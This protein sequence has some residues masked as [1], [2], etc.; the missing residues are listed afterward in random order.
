MI[1]EDGLKILQGFSYE[2]CQNQS[3]Q[4]EYINAHF[5]RIWKTFQVIESFGLS[6]DAKILDVGAKPY[7]LA[8][9]I[10]SSLNS[11]FTG[12]GYSLD[13]IPVEDKD[14]LSKTGS[15]NYKKKNLTLVNKGKNFSIEMHQANVEVDK[16]PFED[17][18][19]DVVVFTE[20]LEHLL[21]DVSFTIKEINR[22]LK[23]NGRLVFSTPNNLFWGRL[24]ALFLGK[25]IDDP[26]SIH[27][28]YGRHNR[29]WTTKEI[30]KLLDVHGLECKN[31]ITDTF[32]AMNAFYL[33][34]ISV[35]LAK[36]FLGL[37]PI[38][39]LNDKKGK[40]LFGVFEKYKHMKEPQYPKW[41]YH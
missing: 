34:R 14:R 17:N 9:L 40:T 32:L 15:V 24:M 20:I 8:I 26:Y 22:V 35:F 27:G 12:I 29:N 39:F 10:K 11:S 25:N 33:K 37:L 36:I 7:M 6:K 23:P 30:R 5:T 16:L 31:L 41:L 28:P 18:S 1:Y 2:G 19:F 21:F 4:Q 13:D 3:E 38:S